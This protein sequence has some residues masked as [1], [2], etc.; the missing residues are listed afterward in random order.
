MKDFNYYSTND[1]PY[2]SWSA[3]CRCG[4]AISK[5]KE[6]VTKFCPECGSNTMDIWEK[7][8][9]LYQ[10]KQTEYKDKSM[11]LHEEFRTDIF[12]EFGVDGNPKKDKCFSIAWEH[13]HAYGYSDVYSYFSDIVELI[14]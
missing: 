5:L 1:F 6:R 11:S 12:R 4:K 9:E 2:P 10:K 14:K 7:E 8:I 13:G 3:H